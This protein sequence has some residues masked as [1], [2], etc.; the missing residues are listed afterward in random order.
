MAT[1]SE[2]EKRIILR[3]FKDLTI[4][5]NSSSISSLIKV[6]RV[7][8]YKS[9][10]NLEKQSILKSEQLGKAF[11]Y[12]LNKNE[13]YAKK[14]IEVLLME[15]GRAKLRWIDEFKEL[16]KYTEVLVLFGSII[17]NE[18]KANDIDLL[19]IMKEENNRIVSKIIEL[20]NEM[21]T[22]KVHILKQTRNDFKSNILKKD[23]VLISAI[24]NG[25]VLSGY[26]KYVEVMLDVSN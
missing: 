6:T 21:L 1:L 7:G 3:I 12:E 10:K 5:Y 18:E 9:L 2:V 15:E 17:K 25:I 16:S 26:E 23:K 14:I 11:F 13:E 8:A 19:I 4:R 22:R 20:K 24:S